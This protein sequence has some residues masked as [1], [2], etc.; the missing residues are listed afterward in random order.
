MRIR[1][2]IIGCLS[3]FICSCTSPRYLPSSETIDVN[4]YGSYI[5]ISTNKTGNIS[6][7]LISI[8]GTT[9]VVLKQSLNKCVSVLIKDVH[10]FSLRYAKPKQYG[11]TIPVYTL[12]TII[13][14]S[15]L[16]FTAPINLM[17]TI[18]VTMSSEDAF[19]YNEKNMSYEKL[20]MFARF[21]QGIPLNIDV[22]S[23]KE[24]PKQP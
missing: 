12:S 9:I 18:G 4:A 15:M 23:I 1:I 14:G 5:R 10:R 22:A 2:I 7:E 8:D 16:V 19:Q 3:L 21:P 24:E 6:G 17:V 11:W 13:H 20:K